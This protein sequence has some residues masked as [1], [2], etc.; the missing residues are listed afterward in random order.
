MF[1]NI[2][3]IMSYHKT[4]EKKFGSTKE[5]NSWEMRERRNRYHKY[6]FG[7]IA[8]IWRRKKNQT[9]RIVFM[10]IVELKDTIIWIYMQRFYLRGGSVSSLSLSHIP[11]RRTSVYCYDL[12]MLSYVPVNHIFCVDLIETW[13]Y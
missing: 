5:A 8:D 9:A 4:W 2:N 3:S 12:G 13:K 11:S 7:L 1:P 6:H 10:N